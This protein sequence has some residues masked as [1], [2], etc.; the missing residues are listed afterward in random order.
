MPRRFLIA[1]PLV[2]LLSLA[3]AWLLWKP[4]LGEEPFGPVYLAPSPRKLRAGEARLYATTVP[5]QDFPRLPLIEAFDHLR[6]DSGAG[7]FIN[8]RALSAAGINK[9][10]PVALRWGATRLEPAVRSVLDQAQA[11]RAG[12]RLDFCEDEGIL[13]I[14]TRD[15]LARNVATRIYD[16]RDL[17]NPDAAPS[18]APTMFPPP[19]KPRHYVHWRIDNLFRPGRGAL[20]KDRIAMFVSEIE[21]TVDPTSWRDAG[22][23]RGSTR[24]LNG[25]LIVTQTEENL[26]SVTY[27]LR[28]RRWQ[29]GVATFAARSLVV[30]LLPALAVTT[31]CLFVLPRRARKRR[32]ARGLCVHCGYDLRA[33]PG[34]CPECGRSAVG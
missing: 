32:L 33:T 23:T 25:Q 15:D 26:S 28:R 2:T 21:H 18:S 9:D 34:R 4:L 17:I 31:I 11:T 8:W 3:A 1:L 13:T 7:I 14:S 27:F 22:G 30:V 16:V 10:T 20:A 5:A 29:I 6:D 24:A 19:A 12:V